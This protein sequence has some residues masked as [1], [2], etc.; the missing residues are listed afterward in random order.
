MLVPA[1]YSGLSNL[2]EFGG[3]VGEK[4]LIEKMLMEY[5]LNMKCMKNRR[6]LL[7]VKTLQ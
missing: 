1:V 2:C 3:G 7:L 4:V 5:P 6:S